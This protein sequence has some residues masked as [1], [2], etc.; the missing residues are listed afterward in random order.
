MKKHG[1][2][3]NSYEGKHLIGAGLQFQRFSPMIMVGSLAVYRLD[4]GRLK[5]PTSRSIGSRRTVRH[6]GHS[7]SI[8]DLKACPYSST[9]PSTRPHLLIVPFS[10]GQAFKPMTLWGLFLFTPAQLCLRSDRIQ[11]WPSSGDVLRYSTTWMRC[12]AYL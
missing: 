8:G 11:S 9:L 3:G 1:D 6:T 5:I 7:L 2:Q 12:L 4:A 10:M